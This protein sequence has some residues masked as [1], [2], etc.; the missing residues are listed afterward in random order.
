LCI[1]RKDEKVLVE[2]RR[3]CTGL[4]LLVFMLISG[5]HVQVSLFEKFH[6]Q[7]LGTR[8]VYML[9][10]VLLWHEVPWYKLQ[11]SVVGPGQGT[12]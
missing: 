8:L 9:C 3:I 2:G 10:F 5:L 6:I 4:Q 1:G 7:K 12:P 11:P